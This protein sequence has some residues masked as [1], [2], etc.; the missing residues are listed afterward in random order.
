MIDK[1]L[2]KYYLRKV[3]KIVEQKLNEYFIHY[4][5]E[6]LIDGV[7]L[8]IKKVEYNDDQY[9]VIWS[10]FTEEAFYYLA[11][12]DKLEKEIDK[13]VRNYNN[14]INLQDK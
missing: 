13:A 12:I 4:R 7:W 10:C 9:K 1:I 5:F 14:W 3:K 11:N 8:E 6:K 2:D